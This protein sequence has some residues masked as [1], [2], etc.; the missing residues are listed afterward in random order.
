MAL[1]CVTTLSSCKSAVNDPNGAGA[2]KI[3]MQ[4]NE[5][6]DETEPF[7]NERLFCVSSDVDMVTA[8]GKL[9]LEGEKAT[10]E[11]KENET[12]KTLWQDTWEGSVESTDF[13]ISLE[14]LKKDAEY[15]IRLT[16][17]EIQEAN[18]TLEFDSDQVRERERP[19]G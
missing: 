14:H 19:A 2:V 11:I 18:L 7:V 3:E 16:G 15:V 13:S 9:E 8:Q 1:A 6:Y 17:T 4:M 5:N 10:V 12:G